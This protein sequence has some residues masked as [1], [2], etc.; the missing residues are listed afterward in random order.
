[1]RNR[2]TR[3]AAALIAAVALV[4]VG[5]GGD[6]GESI[7][8][9]SGR[10]EALVDPLIEQF[11]ESTGIDVDVRYGSSPEM[12]AA[13][14]EEGDE[15]PADVF[16]SQEVGVIGE[17]E[18]A[19]LLAPLPDSVITKVPARF[20]PRATKDWVGVTGR[21]RV[22][23]YNRDLV[24][25]LPTSVLDLTD[26]RYEG[27]VAW[28][29]SNASF[30]S[31]I[32]AFRVSRGEDAARQWLEDMEANGAE[33]YASNTDVLEAVDAGQIPI[34]LINHYYWARKVAEVGGPD[35]LS[36]QLIFPEGDDP[37]ALVN[38]T[39]VSV[40]AHA[41]DD[42]AALEF[43]EYLLSED[44]QTYFATETFEYP[45][46]EGVADPDGLP[47]LEELQGPDIDLADLESLAETQAL[48]NDVGLIS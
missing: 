2:T 45:L 34:G 13:L 9:Y 14:L 38:A 41:A 32:T 40:L 26:P 31:F 20:Q 3:G 11:E 47:A 1:V 21:S 6:D 27:Q 42:P 44:G 12:G 10:D 35:N 29:P 36:A 24:D 15:T 7:T 33:V 5:C 37:G 23:V 19:G 16:F 22:I 28:V 48:L 4:T 18:S 30:Q 8:L 39:A 46:V 43:V 25:E 17:L